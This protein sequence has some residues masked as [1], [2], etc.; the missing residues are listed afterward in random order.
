MCNGCSKGSKECQEIL[1]NGYN[2]YRNEFP[3]LHCVQTSSLTSRLPHY[4]LTSTWGGK[5]PVECRR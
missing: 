1:G 2:K 3:A 5:P 4:T